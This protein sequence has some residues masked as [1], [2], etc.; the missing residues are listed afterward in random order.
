MH[1]SPRWCVTAVL[2]LG[3]LSCSDPVAPPAQ[4]A[5]IATVSAVSPAQAGKSCPVAASLSFDVPGI[6]EKEPTQVLDKD[7]YL[8]KVVDGEGGAGV[9]CTVKS[10]GGGF[11]FSG[12]ISAGVKALEISN[13]TLG[14]DMK[15]TARIV[16]ANNQ[17]LSTPL[18]SQM[19][20]CTVTAAETGSS[21]QVKGGSMWASFRCAA[22]E[23][24]PSE[25]CQA[26]GTF[27]LENCDQ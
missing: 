9:R 27:V 6:R 26:D 17:G 16:L 1:V 7:T 15:G 3:A 5:F 11:T 12:K 13:G 22:V 24:P 21:Y 8:H 4:G 19:P 14:A 25:L 18:A 20:N 23:S 2:A 10:G